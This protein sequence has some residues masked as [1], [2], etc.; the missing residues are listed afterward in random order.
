MIHSIAFI[1]YPVSDV[2][3]A[4][5]FYEEV[6]GLKMARN[7]QDE[8]IEYDLGDTTFAI[9]TAD[10]KHRAGA[11]GGTIAFEV[12]D[13]DAFVKKLKD[14]NAR[15]VTEITAS[16]VCRSAI[17]EDPDANEVIVDKRHAA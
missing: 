8:W 6:L 11:R 12:D 9:T 1:A 13:L 17:V 14:K 2:P 15:F 10:A 5:R 3:G 4:R 16:P 7:F